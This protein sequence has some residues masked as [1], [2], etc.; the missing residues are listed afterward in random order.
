MGHEAQRLKQQVED[1]LK[2]VD[3]LERAKAPVPP[4]IK[5]ILKAMN[6]G[7][8]LAMSAEEASQHFAKF[9]KDLDR[10]CGIGDPAAD[11]DDAWICLAKRERTEGS[12][13]YAGRL[14][15]VL[16]SDNPLSAISIHWSKQK[17]SGWA[18]VWDELRT[19]SPSGLYRKCFIPKGSAGHLPRRGH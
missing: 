19:G 9:I 11:Q 18:C 2:L 12:L 5:Q 14:N 15:F 17:R 4:V 1:A 3:V 7:T 8:E 16:N 13:S 6:E 10:Q